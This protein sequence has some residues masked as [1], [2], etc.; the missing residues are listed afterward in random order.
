M[1]LKNIAIHE[2][3]AILNEIKITRLQ[4]KE[5][6]LKLVHNYLELRKASNALMEDIQAIKSKFQEDWANE[7]REVIVLRKNSE[8]IDEKK[9]ADYL[10][11]EKDAND[12]L[13]AI[14]EGET[15]VDLQPM[16]TDAFVSAMVEDDITLSS[17]GYLSDMGVL[18]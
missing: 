1:L 11:A 4:D 13:S 18:V 2:C 9:Y 14:N 17:I 10:A 16:E 7:L 12:A 15:E 6:K 8:A 3:S 5:L